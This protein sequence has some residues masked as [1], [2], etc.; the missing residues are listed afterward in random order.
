MSFTALAR[1][2][3]LVSVSVGS[4]AAVGT[5]CG[6]SSSDLKG[7]KVTER[8]G[9]SNS[10]YRPT[11]KTHVSKKSQ[12]KFAYESRSA[13]NS[14]RAKCLKSA[15]RGIGQATADDLVSS[16]KLQRTPRDWEQFKS[17]MKSLDR[18]VAEALYDNVVERYG[19]TNKQNLYPSR[20]SYTP[21]PSSGNGGAAKSIWNDLYNGSKSDGLRM[22]Q[23]IRG[24]GESTS[25]K[26][27]PCM[28]SGKPQTWDAFKSKIRSAERDCNATGLYSNVVSKYGSSNKDLLYRR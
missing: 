13:S 2:M 16:G 12:L 28:R 3:F 25:K 1:K 22:L 21:P 5:S 17:H 4:L 8:G 18:S 26:I 14:E 11:C 6:T 20:P 9:S 10:N 27:Y 19:S 24:V 23:R 7:I 15:V